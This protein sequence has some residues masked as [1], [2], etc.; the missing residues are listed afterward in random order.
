MK[1][2]LNTKLVPLASIAFLAAAATGLVGCDVD[3]D[4]GAA[5]LPEYEVIKTDE[6]N[7][8]MPDVDVEGPDLETGTTTIE[9]PTIGL[10]IPEE[11]DADAGEPEA[12]Q[13][14]EE[15]GVTTPNTY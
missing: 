14:L 3:V 13:E 4:P 9:V 6:G 11:G 10:D 7:F 1:F 8:D 5:E 2:D 15:E 12:V